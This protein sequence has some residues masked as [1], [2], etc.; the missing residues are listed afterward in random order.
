MAAI[1]AKRPA[2]IDVKLRIASVDV[3]IG[4]IP[5]VPTVTRDV[6]NWGGLSKWAGQ[7]G[8]R[9]EWRGDLERNRRSARLASHAIFLFAPHDDA[10]RVARRGP[11]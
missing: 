4:R 2:G 11:L 3:A 8:R 7:G 5:D 6:G 9:R 1:C 10:Q